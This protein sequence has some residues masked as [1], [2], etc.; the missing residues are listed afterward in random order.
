M[1]IRNCFAEK[2]FVRTVPC[3]LEVM[4]ER[5]EPIVFVQK[6][7]LEISSECFCAKRRHSCAVLKRLR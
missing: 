3:A 1:Q 5:E 4:F 7:S 2:K 6:N